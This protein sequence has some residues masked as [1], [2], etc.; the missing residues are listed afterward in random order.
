M[1]ELIGEKG[2][3]KKPGGGLQHLKVEEPQRQKGGTRR[4]DLLIEGVPWKLW[5]NCG[6]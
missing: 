3:K 1:E 6:S 5:D 2:A 4:D